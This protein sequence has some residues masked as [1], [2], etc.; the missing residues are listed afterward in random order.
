MKSVLVIPDK[1]KGSLTADQAARA[2]AAG[3]R[4]RKHAFRVT[5]LPLSDGGE[6][7]VE[8][9]A[10][11]EGGK[12]HFRPT[13]DPLGRP[14]RAAFAALPDG[15]AVIGLT[16]ASGLAHV[17]A[18]RRDPGTASNLGTGR[19][20]A[21]A[22]RAGFRRIVIGLGGSATND[23]GIGLA[24]PLGFRFLDARGRSIPL[25]G[26]GLARL[27]RIVPPPRLPKLEIIVA[28]DVGHPLYGPE[29][30]AHQFAAQKGATPEQIVR[31]DANLRRLAAV[32]RRSLGKSPHLRAG[33]G[34]AGGCGYGLMAF[35][36][37]RRVA[38][39]DYFARAV[40]LRKRIAEH[41]LIVTGE[42]CFDRT[43][44]GGKGPWAVGALARQVGKEAW[45]VCGKY[46][47]DERERA[48]SPFSRTVELL[49]IAPSPE[50]ARREAARY[51]REG[52]AE[53]ARQGAT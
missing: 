30:A 39:F 6:G 19:L 11:A 34:A 25:N 2:I 36:G 22:V 20:L 50:A 3:L 40:S 43:S 41:D 23:G 47:L 12:L 44:L 24:A 10:R 28:C 17:P 52:V 31:L 14:R 27:D 49:A 48:R 7:F 4:E 35:F 21:A 32:V 46:A 29:G 8:I 1:F 9:L 16:E 5:L 51:V 53:L 33:A 42:G 38:G 45:L 15:T 37:A 18:A 26:E 13:L